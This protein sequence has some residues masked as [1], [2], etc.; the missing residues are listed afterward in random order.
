MSQMS[1]DQASVFAK[2]VELDEMKKL[3]EEQ[4]KTIESLKERV[5]KLE[6]D[7]SVTETG[8]SAI[9]NALELHGILKN[10]EPVETSE[11][12]PTWDPAKIKWELRE[13]SKGVYERSEDVNNLEFKKMLQDLGAHKGK[14]FR[15]GWFYWLFID[16]SVVGRKQR[17]KAK[18]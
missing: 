1:L 18:P 4:R 8:L 9:A 7:A 16:G 5:I 2:L 15:G 13:G 3:V 11:K 10:G 6:V 17:L 14:L 12:E